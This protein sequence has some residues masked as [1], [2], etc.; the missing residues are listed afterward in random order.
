MSAPT[1]GSL[2]IREDL[3]ITGEAVALQLPPASLPLR[4]L[5]C[6]IDV[7][8]TV[9]VF[10]AVLY[11]LTNVMRGTNQAQMAT[12][13]ITLV[14]TMVLVV[15]TVVETVTQGQS[16][17]KK[18]MGLR[19]VRTDGGPVRL[20]HSMVRATTGF[21][22]IWLTLGSGALICGILDRRS[23]R[24]GDLLAGTYAVLERTGPGPKLDLAVAPR[25]AQW[26]TYA[27]VQ[28]L[29]DGLTA[30]A[31]GFLERTG[32]LAPHVRAEHGR[33][34]A[35]ALTSYVAPAP[36]AGTEPEDLVCTV[37][38][39][40]RERELELGLAVAERS[41]AEIAALSALPHGITDPA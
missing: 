4:I 28:K 40:R 18:A 8:A 37:L 34:I 23:R 3:V 9:V 1:D 7:I 11:A 38:A 35:E 24:I 5:S 39:L 22:E 25:L 12:V 6:L 41:R 15:P 26:A 17:G 16:L 30:S 29:P 31:R 21:L 33:L 27:Q 13:L 14:A 20:R 10:V 32:R 36:P 2:L 19:V